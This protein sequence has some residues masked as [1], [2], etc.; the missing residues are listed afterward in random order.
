[1][2]ARI[3][4]DVH[5]HQYNFDD[6][7]KYLKEFPTGDCDAIF[8]AG[9]FVDIH[10]KD[11]WLGILAEKAKADG[12]RVFFVPGNHEYWD[13]NRDDVH[14]E[15]QKVEE[16][17]EN[18]KWLRDFQTQLF[19]I[20]GKT[21]LIS[22]DTGWFNCN[23]PGTTANNWCDYKYSEKGHRLFI[24]EKNCVNHSN[25]DELFDH[26]SKQKEVLRYDCKI[27]MTHHIPCMNSISP[28]Y[29]SYNNNCF[30]Y[31]SYFEHKL[32]Y[33]LNP[34]DVWIH[35]HVHSCWDY[36]FN[37]TR[38]CARPVGYS[39]ERKEQYPEICINEYGELFDF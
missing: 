28:R 22:G 27:F 26:Q 15:L 9:D 37:K 31:N 17:Y 1:M 38:V 39:F 32:V 4:S 6:I 16:K 33:G 35:G 11:K 19:Y 3:L 7:T 29:V 13:E 23:H 10:N 24:Q 20:D 25:L 34:P 14:S 21:Y 12:Q 36:Q 18:F 5:F 30:Y 8:I 2:K